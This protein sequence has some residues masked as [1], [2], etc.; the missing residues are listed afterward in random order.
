M[1]NQGTT[2]YTTRIETNRWESLI[3]LTFTY[4]ADPEYD[5]EQEFKLEKGGLVETLKR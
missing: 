2:R 3:R 4:F 1:V 5:V